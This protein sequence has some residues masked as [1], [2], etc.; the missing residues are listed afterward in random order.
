MMNSTPKIR[1]VLWSSANPPSLSADILGRRSP[2]R[3][4][5]GAFSDR[6]PVPRVRLLPSMCPTWSR[7][8]PAIESAQ[9]NPGHLRSYFREAADHCRTCR[10][11]G[12]PHLT[13]WG[14]SLEG[15]PGRCGLTRPSLYA[16]V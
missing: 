15:L 16:M 4:E 10:R 8:T 13:G 5:H 2:T 9:A 11:E 7:E 6:A 14:R 1:A 12:I 3:N